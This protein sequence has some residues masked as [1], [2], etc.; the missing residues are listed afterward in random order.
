MK[1]LKHIG[2][3][4]DTNAKVL[5]VFRTLPGESDHALVL[6]V[7]VLPSENHDNIM[8]LLE[9]RQA[10]D[11]FEFGEIMFIRKFSDGRSMLAAANYDKML[12]RVA[13]DQIIMTP[14][15]SD[16][17]LLSELNVLIA[18]Q[19]NCAV[20]DLYTFVS[21]AA[22]VEDVVKINDLG[23]D[24]G[25]PN[26]PEYEAK[27]EP[28]DTLTDESIATSYRN[29]A[30]SMM[31]EAQR[32]LEEAEQLAPTKK[33]PAKKKAATKKKP[34]A[35]KATAKKATAKKATGKKKASAISE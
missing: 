6:P 22:K 26:V 31:K 10:Q 4:K 24:V 8:N 9:T 27:T 5:V 33:A 3:M 19:K 34:A 7:S 13:T 23:R 25:E 15:T 1:S 18:E 2:R 20:D 16:E 14:N 12:K 32:L 17:I 30:D 11:V 21:G 35:K 28:V 29:Q